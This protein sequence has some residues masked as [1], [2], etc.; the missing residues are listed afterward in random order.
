MK[1]SSVLATVNWVPA[2]LYARDRR[3]LTPRE[4]HQEGLWHA[5]IVFCKAHKDILSI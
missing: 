4:R 2:I 3:L 1:R 5:G